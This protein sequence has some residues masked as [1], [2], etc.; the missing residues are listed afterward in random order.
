MPILGLPNESS[1]LMEA[2]DTAVPVAGRR[3]EKRGER[4]RKE[5]NGE[6]GGRN[7]EKG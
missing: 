2:R 7:G 3:E 4:G 1:M 5:S 6:E